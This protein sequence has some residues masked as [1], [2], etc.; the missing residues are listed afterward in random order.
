LQAVHQGHSASAN[1]IDF[2]L[3]ALDSPARAE[4]AVLAIA[5]EF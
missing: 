1:R 2:M 4:L 5:R 3:R